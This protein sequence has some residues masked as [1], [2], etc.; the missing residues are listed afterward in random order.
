MTRWML[1]PLALCLLVT[2]TGHAAPP[3]TAAEVEAAV[4]TVRGEYKAINTMIRKKQLRRLKLSIGGGQNPNSVETYYE[5]GSERDFERD[6]Y[7]CPFRVRLIKLSRVLPATGPAGAEFYFTSGGQLVFVDASGMDI[8]GAG[9]YLT[10]P[11]ERLRVYFAGGE[12]F[13]MLHDAA[14]TE[15]QD[16][17]LVAPAIRKR[18]I[19]AGAAFLGHARRLHTALGTLASCD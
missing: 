19:K 12:A 6:V 13:R 3:R 9:G 7:A 17:P 1:A 5:G 15:R 10:R 8:W 18:G 4:K 2:A 16:L 14:R 11:T